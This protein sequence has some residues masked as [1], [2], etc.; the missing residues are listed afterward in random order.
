MIRNGNRRV[1][2][3]GR[4][5]L[6]LYPGDY[7]TSGG[8]G[9]IY[10]TGNTV[11]KIYADAKKMARD[12]MAD[13]IA[14]LSAL[15]HPF[16]VAPK[17][18]VRDERGVPIGYYMDF[19]DGELLPRL[20]TNDFRTRVGFSD[21]G[22][23]TLVAGMREAVLAAHAHKAIMV[24]GNEF[25]WLALL[26]GKQKP[27]PR[28]IDVD[29]WAIGRWPATVVM[30]SI[31][32]RHIKGFTEFSD[33][34][35]WGVVSFQVFIGIHPYKGKLDGFL[36]GD[37]EGRMKA[38]AS[39]F[40]KDIRLN[41][42]VRDFSVIPRPLYDWYRG[43][44]QNGERSVPPSPFAKS[45]SIIAGAKTFYATASGSGLLVHSKLF[46]QSGE[47]AVRVFP[48]GI[49]LLDSGGLFNLS[50]KRYIGKVSSLDCEVVWIKD[51]W[52][53]AES[54]KGGVSFSFI[55]ATAG[56]SIPLNATQQY[57][58]IFR[59]DDRLFAVSEGSLVEL[60][61]RF[62]KSP[63]LVVEKTWGIMKQ[64]ALFF[65]GVGV[66]SALGAAYLIVPFGER[67]CVF[68]R[69]RELD[70]LTVLS[71][72]GGTRFAA[73]VAVDRRGVFYKL[74]FTFDEAYAS[75]RLRRGGVDNPDLNMAI[76]PKGV[77]ATIVDDG[78]LVIFAPTFGAVNRVSDKSITAD[79]QLFRHEDRVVY[80]RNGEV[81][82][83]QL[84]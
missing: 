16:I 7:I 3:E 17:G 22:A 64:S 42:A 9:A 12:G 8:E 14:L 2:L 49:A 29:S 30:P 71:A 76:L 66:Q 75:Y 57:S 19:A 77:C 13:K 59:A 24:D 33:W 84:K 74:E 47:C 4:G 68:I 36:P 65:D 80:V 32:D 35:S 69:A 72:K 28:V 1:V 15:S 54:I 61:V 50:A 63:M 83:V 40:S 81:W 25:N 26:Q 79:A 39:V 55:D 21:A 48:S 60:G 5:A 34:F 27:E 6:T 73:I 20:F 11:V 78:E 56:G 38:N 53:V 10:R 58:R 51:G 23:T 18:L 67:S 37:L 45:A 46:G 52:L 44:F 43:V 31:L 41:K 82:R 62:G 70:E